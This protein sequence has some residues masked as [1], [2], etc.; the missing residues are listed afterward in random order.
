MNF[1]EWIFC[2]LHAKAPEMYE[3]LRKLLTLATEPEKAG[4]CEWPSHLGNII[5]HA[6][7]IKAAI[8]GEG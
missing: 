7:R 5:E 6:R 3:L 1:S 8:D 4:D 2:P